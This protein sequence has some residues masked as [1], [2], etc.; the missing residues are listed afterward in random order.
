MK[1][2]IPILK[3]KNFRYL[4]TS[5]WTSQLTINMMNFLL[6]TQLFARTG[7]SIA[8]SFLW[9][10]Y[11]LPA[12]LAGPFAAATVDMTSRRWMLIL[13]NLLQ[14]ATILIYALLQR[15]SLFLLFGTVFVYSLL[16][17]FYVPAESASLP[18][19]VPKEHLPHA[20]SLFFLTQQGTLV[21]GFAISGVM[22][23]FFGFEISLIV[24]AFFVFIAFVS[25]IF[26]PEMRP[27]ERLPEKFEEAVVKFFKSITGGYDF[28]KEHRQ[29]LLP[30]II[31]IVL[32]I[33]LSVMVVS[34]PVL[35]KDI[36][37][38]NLNSAGVVM[39]VPAG[40]GAA[41]GAIVLTKLIKKGWR[42][43]TAIELFLTILTLSLMMMIFIIPEIN[44]V[45]RIAA[46]YLTLILAAAAGIGLMIAAQTYMQETTPEE[47]RGR[48]FGN[49]W[50]ITTA[51]SVIPVIFSGTLVDILGIKTLLFLLAGVC[52]VG[53][54]FSKK[55]GQQFLEKSFKHE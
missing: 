7:S 27:K 4:W 24:C 21:L 5:Q 26:L 29:M 1:D 42:K 46:S 54:V 44:L 55:Y 40:I 45:L 31:L 6:L 49:F 52:L 32:Q 11:S 43:K 39:V 16:N 10:A 33:S 18:S 30:Y 47:L 50:F 28:I 15:S 35:A 23:Q 53:M 14:S 2:F 8:T 38:I 3:N 48:V 41:L 20:N 17:Q 25:V 51:L 34:L 36:F 22:A 37:K 12:L 19:L 13:T 9:I